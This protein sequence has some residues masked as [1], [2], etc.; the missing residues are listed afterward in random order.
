MFGI[1]ESE[2]GITPG[3]G[4]PEDAHCL[5][6]YTF[7][8]SP[9]RA[10][11]G[12]R[13]FYIVMCIIHL[14]YWGIMLIISSIA[15]V[16]RSG[17]MYTL[18]KANQYRTTSRLH[19]ATGLSQQQLRYIYNFHRFSTM[20]WMILSVI[21][22]EFTLNYN[23]M[24]DVL[25][26]R[27]HLFFPSQ[28]IPL[29]IG[30]CGFFR[31]IYV[32]F[33]QWRSPEDA[34]PSL[35]VDEPLT[36]LKVSSMPHGKNKLKLF[37]RGSTFAGRRTEKHH[38]N[39]MDPLLD[40]QPLYIRLLLSY[41]PWLVLVRWWHLRDRDYE[42]TTYSQP[43]VPTLQV[44][45]TRPDPVNIGKHESR[46]SGKTDVE[47]PQQNPGRRNDGITEQESS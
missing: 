38:S 26:W 22:V 10:N 29:T 2:P 30:I 3:T 7:M 27:G 41:L 8:F 47:S 24:Y 13:I 45:V 35:S 11:G 15:A 1:A 34:D 20:F 39:E 16:A 33:E 40:G 21:I 5:S 46:G 18:F 25:G 9:V 4:H 14:I 44:S 43:T 42:Q 28:L 37:A 6:L 17:K 12:I 23:K 32:S 31:V 36:P 19:Y